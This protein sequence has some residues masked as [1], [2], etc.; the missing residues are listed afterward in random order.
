MLYVGRAQVRSA[1]N[2]C[3]RPHNLQE[4]LVKHITTV[5]KLIF[6]F[7]SCLLE[8]QMKGSNVAISPYGILPIISSKNSR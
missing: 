5:H 6:N 1:C 2:G 7:I 4:L 3:G 8:L